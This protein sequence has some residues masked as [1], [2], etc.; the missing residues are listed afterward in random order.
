MKLED[1]V[2]DPEFRD[3]IPPLSPD[4]LD[5]LEKAITDSGEVLDPLKVW[6]GTGILLDGHNRYN[7]LQKYPGLISAHAYQVKELEFEDRHAAA[8]WICANQ[9]GRRN[10]SDHQKT[11]I[12]GREY[13]ERKLTAGEFHGN[14]YTTESGCPQNEDDQKRS[15]NS[16][17]SRTVMAIAKEHGVGHATVERSEQYLNGIEK[18]QTVD[19]EFA[20][21]IE[22]RKI[23]PTKAQVIALRNLEGEELKEAVKGIREGKKAEK[24]KPAESNLPKQNRPGRTKEMREIE[25]KIGEVIGDTYNVD[26]PPM[27]YTID[28]LKEDYRLA[29]RAILDQFTFILD[30]HREIAISSEGKDVFI[31]F[32]N[33]LGDE[34]N[35]MFGVDAE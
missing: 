4:E 23:K 26:A 16:K 5:R 27:E 32:M 21:D 15:E 11:M 2:V 20:A 7:I 19:P 29:K 31:E 3:I 18:A 8:A 35:R 17:S 24:P 1:I 6:K 14:Q 33:D 28:S 34:L 30:H 22:S 10:L 12:L 9:L 13:R 25:Q